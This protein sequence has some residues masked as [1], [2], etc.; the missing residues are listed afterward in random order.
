MIAYASILNQ[1]FTSIFVG[2]FSHISYSRETIFC[3][4]LATS[5]I[6]P[7]SLRQVSLIC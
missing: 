3:Y 7:K 5:T 6:T 2:K 4:V 1:F